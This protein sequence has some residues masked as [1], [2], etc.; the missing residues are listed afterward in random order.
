M[1]C[2]LC[3]KPVSTE[4]DYISS[5]QLRDIL[6]KKYGYPSN[7]DHSDISY[8]EALEDAGVDGADELIEAIRKHDV[9][10]IFKE[11]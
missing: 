9:I 5:Y 1:T 7:L 8:L 2:S 10:Q 3:W 6:E 4:R 11:C